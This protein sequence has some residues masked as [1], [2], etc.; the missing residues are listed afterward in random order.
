M[1]IPRTYRKFDTDRTIYNDAKQA[2][3]LYRYKHPFYKSGYNVF[4]IARGKQ[5]KFIH[6]RIEL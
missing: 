2:Q 3:I 1:L 5:E 6:V 4:G